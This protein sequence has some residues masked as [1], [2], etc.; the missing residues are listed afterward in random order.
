M[1]SLYEFVLIYV[2]TV[3]AFKTHVLVYN[4]VC[5][6]I[7]VEVQRQLFVS[8]PFFVLSKYETY[9]D[10]LPSNPNESKF[11]NLFLM[12]F[13]DSFLYVFKVVSVH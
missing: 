1:R 12:S 3:W 10:S 9:F 8:W 6:L 11:W 2:Y 7:V 5:I 13:T 4:F